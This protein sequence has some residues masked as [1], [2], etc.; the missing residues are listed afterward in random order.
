[1]LLDTQKRFVDIAAE[2]VIAQ[3]V[4]TGIGGGQVIENLR[5]LLAGGDE[6]THAIHERNG[7]F[8][9]SGEHSVDGIGR[10]ALVF[11]HHLGAR[12]EEID[13]FRTHGGGVEFDALGRIALKR[14]VDRSA[15]RNVD[16]LV[17]EQHGHDAQSAATQG[18][19]VGRARGALAYGEQAA[20]GIE[21]VGDGHDAANA[22]GGYLVARKTRAIM[23]GDGA[24]NGVG[25]ARGFS[26]IATHDALHAREFHDGARHQVGL[27]QERRA[28]NV[29]RFPSAN[30]RVG[31]DRLSERHNAIGLRTRRA[32]FL[33]EHDRVEPLDVILQRKF[34]V[35]VIEEF[36]IV[37]AR[38]HDA[39]IAVDDVVFEFRIAVRGDQ[40]FVRKRPIRVEQREIALVHEHGVNGDLLR[41]GQEQL[42]EL[43]H[44]DR[45]EFGQVH[46]FG[47]GLRGKLGHKARFL[48][49]GR[50][51]LANRSLALCLGGNDEMLTQHIDEAVCRGNLPRP[52]R[53]EAMAAR[54]VTR[55]KPRE[56]NGDHGFA[57]HGEQPAHRA[58][59]MLM[60]RAPT[61]RA[62]PV[63][64]GDEILQ[65]IGQKRIDLNGRGRFYGVHIF[66]AVLVAPF[67]R[68]CVNAFAA[69]E[70]ERGLRG[71]AV[72]I[73]GDFR[74][75]AAKRFGQRLGCL[76]NV[77]HTYD[78]AARRGIHRDGP[79]G[80]AR[81]VK[82]AGE[83]CAQLRGGVA[84]REGGQL[85]G[86][87][88]KRERLVCHGYL[89][90][91][92]LLR[93]LHADHVLQIARAA[94]LRDGAHAQDIAHALGGGNHAARIEQVERMAA[95]EHIVVCGKRQARGQHAIAF[96][97]VA[98]EFAEKHI[99]VGHFEVVR[100]E[101]A[102]VFQENVAVREV[103]AVGA[104]APHDIVDGIHALHVHGQTLQ[105]IGDFRGNRVALKTAHLLEI[106]ELGDLHTVD[107][108]FPTEAPRTKRRA[109]PVVLDETNVM[110]SHRDANGFE[111]AQVEVLDIVGRR[112][113]Q[114]LELIIVL[115]TIRIF[116]ITAIGGTAARLYIACAPRIGAERAQR[117]GRMKRASAYFVVVGLHN[118]AAV[119]CPIALQSQ[120]DLLKRGRLGPGSFAHL[121]HSYMVE[122]PINRDSSTGNG[123]AVDGS[124]IAGIGGIGAIVTHHPEISLG[125]GV[126][127]G[128]RDAR[129]RFQRFGGFALR[130]GL[131]LRDTVDVND[132]IDK[133]DRL[134]TRCDNTLNQGS[135]RNDG[136]FESDDVT[137]LRASRIVGDFLGPHVVAHFDGVFHRPR[138]D[139]V[140]AHDEV[141]QEPYQRDDEDDVER[142]RKRLAGAGAKR[143]RVM[144][145]IGHET[146]ILSN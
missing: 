49:D 71:V 13:D 112:L 98:V 94:C 87:D 77:E 48:L 86:S 145:T 66:H 126:G 34:Q 120:D 63:D 54:R 135:S 93:R 18:E 40:E 16:A 139:G 29:G 72:R 110:L 15:Q 43:A 142:P 3:I 79:M 115:H 41:N 8:D 105:A 78:E 39:L 6:R 59:E 62:R 128:D 33:L 19:R 129:R 36:R 52:G 70:A 26:V 76:G 102:L 37:E 133:V 127:I 95:F 99:G 111:A 109:F 67:E 42:V 113:H 21:F 123:P 141:L 64:G 75:G 121:Q 130:I 56:L 100:G 101:L 117:S 138:R 106:G 107:P 125:N 81:G 108:D 24:R 58:A 74:R 144:L 20:D 60:A 57:V 14:H 1:M 69:R 91:L 124:E 96:S 53:Q 114:H 45:G 28:L 132:A 55:I 131:I 88:F 7:L 10:G 118:N 32:Q 22:L 84:Q 23:V 80:N 5:L 136:I 97:L 35:F 89:R 44:H 146:H 134:S 4:R 47:H 31:R 38:G 27:A 92:A 50:D 9:A 46:D 83:G 2:L 73:E 82:R 116:A 17:G 65:N 90:L 25:F 61:L 11:G 12:D 30:A 51:L 119:V 103:E 85:L 140:G 122:G 137:S 104:S 68:A 143:A